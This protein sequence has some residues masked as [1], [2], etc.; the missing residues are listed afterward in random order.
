MP[1][2]LLAVGWVRGG[3][4]CGERSRRAVWQTIGLVLFKGRL[5]CWP[6]FGTTRPPGQEI[7]HGSLTNPTISRNVPPKCMPNDAIPL[8]HLPHEAPA[9]PPDLL[10]RSL[11]KERAQP[12][13]SNTAAQATALQELPCLVP[14]GAVRAHLLLGGLQ[15]GGDARESQGAAACSALRQDSAGVHVHAA[16]RRHAYHDC[17]GCF[18]SSRCFQQSGECRRRRIRTGGNPLHA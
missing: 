14:A 6:S 4:L 13:A 1:A 5:R 11:R 16:I 18:Q 15:A 8:L 7:E 9:P 17:A 3:M 2:A 10:L 12:K